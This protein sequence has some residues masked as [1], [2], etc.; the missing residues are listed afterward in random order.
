M[1]RAKTNNNQNG[2]KTAI[3]FIRKDIAEIKANIIRLNDTF[4]TFEAGRLTS[5]EKDFAAHQADMKI[6]KK[7]V[8]GLVGL[9]LTGVVVAI[10]AL[11]LRTP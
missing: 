9:I 8:F 11:V 7:I 10:L 5:L 3:D 4:Q 1:S 2:I 6:I